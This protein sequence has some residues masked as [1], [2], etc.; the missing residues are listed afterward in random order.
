MFSQHVKVD[1]ILDG[2]EVVLFPGWT[3]NKFVL[4][5]AT[6]T[7]NHPEQEYLCGGTIQIHVSVGF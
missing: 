6:A 1:L 7:H 2:S 5:V 3:T 4:V